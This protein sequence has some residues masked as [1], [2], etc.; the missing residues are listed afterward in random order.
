MPGGGE[1]AAGDYSLNLTGGRLT[2][3]AEGDGLDS[4]GDAVVSGGTVV[5]HGPRSNGNGALEVNGA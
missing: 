1:T 4:N 5:V 2:I 3:N